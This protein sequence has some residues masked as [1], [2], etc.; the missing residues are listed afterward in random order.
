MENLD[1]LWLILAVGNSSFI[2]A[3]Y[4]NQFN[5]KLYSGRRRFLTQYVKKFPLPNPSTDI[6]VK[7]ISTVKNLYQSLINGSNIQTQELE[8]D[9]LIWKSF[10]LDKK[11]TW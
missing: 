10:G 5:N 11:V 7:I 3:Y 1:M 2:E 9:D 4:D 8:L 6:A